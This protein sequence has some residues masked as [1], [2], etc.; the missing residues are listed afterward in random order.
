MED[1]IYITKVT[2]KITPFVEGYLERKYPVGRLTEM[3]DLEEI[4]ALVME[5]DGALLKKYPEM[6]GELDLKASGETQGRFFCWWYIL[7]WMIVKW[8][9]WRIHRK[10]HCPCDCCPHEEKPK[11]HKKGKC[12]NRK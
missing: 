10:R 1:N 5:I 7:W 11:H 6:M 4:D 9:I 3:P 2:D 12:C 8:I